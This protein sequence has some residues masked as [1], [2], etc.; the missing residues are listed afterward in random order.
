M[1]VEF[2]IVTRYFSDRGFGFVSRELSGTQQDVIF[3][4]IST[5]EKS[6]PELA[7]AVKS[8]GD[9]ETT[10]FWYETGS[11]PKGPQVVDTLDYEDIISLPKND[12]IRVVEK[13][14]T[15]WKNLSFQLPEWMIQVAKNT[16]SPEL[17]NEIESSR[18]AEIEKVK[19]QRLSKPSS[20]KLIPKSTSLFDS[21]EEKE[22]QLL[23]EEIKALGFE[24]SVQVSNYIVK[25]RLG[26]K[27]QNISGHLE[28]SR[29][30]DTW[31]FDGG[32]PPAIYG[33]LCTELG[34][35]NNGSSARPSKFTSYKALYNNGK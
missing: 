25:R 15:L 20:K 6:F 19:L 34:L 22:F 1:N 26:L 2:G 9:D 12:F 5:L 17:F 8:Q 13:L 23:V 4:H 11:S 31:T 35:N 18:K 7:N 28:M 21:T 10:F 33:R 27:Y 24:H 32:F 3:F 29:N 30:G 16:L 14:K